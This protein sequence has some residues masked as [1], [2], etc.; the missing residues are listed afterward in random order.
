MKC[1]YCDS[2]IQNIPEN[3]VCPYCGGIFSFGKRLDLDAYFLRYQPNR[4][5][6]IKA[7]R[8][9]TGIG[10]I[11]AKNLIDDL[12]DRRLGESHDRDVA[13]AKA[14]LQYAFRELK[15]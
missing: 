1:D 5:K 7:L 8:K 13:V 4:V 10:L 15:K 3:H 6:A 9:D 14:N 12:F 2:N 11:E